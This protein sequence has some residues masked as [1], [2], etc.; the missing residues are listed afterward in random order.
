ML[1]P[2]PTVPK[3]LS[4]SS[5]G[6]LMTMQEFETIDD[7]EDGFRYELIHGV[8]VVTP[9]ASDSEVSS[10]QRLGY[11][12]DRY[13]EEHPQG[14]CIDDTLFE[15]PV[16]TLDSLRRTD[17]SIWIGLG[18][19]PDSKVDVPTIIVEFVSPGKA[20]FY[21]DYVEKRDEYLKVGCK[22]YWVFDRFDRTMTIFRA[23]AEPQTITEG[24]IFTTPLLP[25]FELPLSKILTAGDR[26]SK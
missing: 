18:R 14:K 20:A 23:N 1:M 12:L 16:R 24:Q 10:N 19:A 13:Q 7:F 5:A 21:R 25:G 3:R 17:R 4:A 6:L 2:L 8:V 9:P 26:Y 15:R 22:E 11:L